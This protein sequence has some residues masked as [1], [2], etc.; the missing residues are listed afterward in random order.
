M[1]DIPFSEFNWLAI[2]A[3][4]V[5]GQVISTIWFVLV[6]PEPWAKAY[7]ASSAKEHTKEIPGYTYGVGLV[8]T[9]LLTISLATLQQWLKI[10]TLSGAISLGLFISIGFSAATSLPGHAFLKRWSAFWMI[11]GSQ[12]AMILGI[13]TILAL[14]K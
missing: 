13:S 3:S 4:V 11:I 8:C 5:A 2:A 9:I 6:V 14:W 12:T 7:G 10:D 1:I